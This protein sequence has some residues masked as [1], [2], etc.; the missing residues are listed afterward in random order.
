MFFN[1]DVVQ[2]DIRPNRVSDKRWTRW[3]G[4]NAVELDGPIAFRKSVEVLRTG[5][6]DFGRVVDF[7]DGTHLNG[8]EARCY[9]CHDTVGV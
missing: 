9:F 3:R 7:M 4:S 1:I 8:A 5:W 6:I 2:T